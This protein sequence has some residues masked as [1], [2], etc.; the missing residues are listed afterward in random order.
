MTAGC[1]YWQKVQQVAYDFGMLQRSMLMPLFNVYADV[2]DETEGTL[3]CLACDTNLWVK[4]YALV[5]TAVIQRCLNNFQS[6]P[7][8]ALWSLT[9]ANVS[10][11]DVKNPCKT[12][13]A[14]CQ[15]SGKQL[16]EK[17]GWQFECQQCSLVAKV[18]NF[19]VICLNKGADS[20][21]R[22]W[23]LPLS[24]FEATSEILCPN[25]GFTVSDGYWQ[26]SKPG[27]RPLMC[28]KVTGECDK[29][30]QENRGEGRGNTAILN[31]QNRSL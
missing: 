17:E 31:S 27:R 14:R 23:N 1:A 29:R 9:K 28:N 3:N 26:W 11:C 8:S 4:A 25:L 5:S 30:V 24:T 15:M 6:R 7:S 12:G 21:L 22:E 20:R 10:I 2:L 13:Q 16:F 19:T 18:S